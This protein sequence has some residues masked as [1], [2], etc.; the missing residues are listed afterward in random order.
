MEQT[1]RR[2]RGPLENPRH[3]AYC[4]ARAEGAT[5]R[6]AMRRAFPARASWKDATIDRKACDL[7]KLPEVAARVEELKRAAEAAVVR[8][9]DVLADM[10]R[11]FKAAVG[12]VEGAGPEGRLEGAALSAVSSIGRALLDGLPADEPPERPAFV[13]DMGLMVAPPHLA[14]HRAAARGGGDFWLFGGRFSGKSSYISLEVVNL[15]M[16]D[17]SRSA[18]VAMKVGKDMRGSVYEQ[19]LWAL[20]EMGVAGEWDCTVSPMR[21]VRRATGQAVAFK[22]CDGAEKFKGVKAPSG[23]YFAVVWLEEVDQ[24]DGPGEVRTVLQSTTRGAGAGAP[25]WRFRSFNPPRSKD[26]WSNREIA[27]REAKGLPVYR[28]SY[29]DMPVEWVPEQVRLDAQALKEADP[30]SYAHEYLGEPVGYGAEVFPRAVARPVTDDERRRLERHCYGVDWGFASDPFCWLKVAYDQASRTLYVLDE[31]SGLGLSNAESAA[32]VS[33]R[34]GEPRLDGDGGVVEDAEP[35]ARVMCDSAEP[36]SIDEWRCLGILAEGAPKQGAH[37]V[38]SGVRW[39]QE[40]AAIVVDSSCELAARELT[41]YQYARTKEG[42]LTSRLPDSDNHAVDA[43]RYAVS[44]LIADR[45]VK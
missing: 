41:C 10:G 24:F 38:R 42:E 21:M 30:E 26:S 27:D 19:M 18:L 11:A 4:V 13:R 29:L 36:K 8:R 43:L 22:G 33:A 28:S 1:T 37:S 39:L 7:E 9:A 23:T 17:E 12:R 44:T 15:L 45:T 6:Q 5:Q 34:M 31:V 16:Q 25:F 3:E 14:P 32:M 35:Y 20:S 40:R 2:G